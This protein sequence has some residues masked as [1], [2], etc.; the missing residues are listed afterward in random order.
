MSRTARVHLFNPSLPWC[1]WLKFYLRPPENGATSTDQTVFGQNESL[2]S[3]W[4]LEIAE[5]GNYPY[6]HSGQE[7]PEERQKQ[8]G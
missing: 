2:R 7:T 6:R 3:G 1:P 8:G 5:R 4:T